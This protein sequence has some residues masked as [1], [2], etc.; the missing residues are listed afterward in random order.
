M[1]VAKDKKG[2]KT[3]TLVERE[4]NYLKIIRLVT[5]YFD[6]EIK[7]KLFS[8]FLYEICIARLGY[9]ESVNLGFEIDLDDDKNEL[10][11]TEVPDDIAKK[12]IE[13]NR[14]E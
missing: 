7:N 13:R 8:G 10:K 4:V 1:G 6:P 5:Q 11:V 14:Q 3:H 2:I 9:D 12:A